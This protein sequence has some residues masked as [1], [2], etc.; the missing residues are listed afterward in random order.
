MHRR[1]EKR[2]SIG[3]TSGGT[4]HGKKGGKSPAFLV[5]PGKKK[6]FPQRHRENRKRGEDTIAC[7]LSYSTSNSQPEGR[8]GRKT[9]FP[10]PT[11]RTKGKKGGKVVRPGALFSYRLGEREGKKRPQGKRRGEKGHCSTHPALAKRK[12]LSYRPIGT[13]LRMRKRGK[14]GER[15]FRCHFLLINSESFQGRG[16]KRGERGYVSPAFF[17][18]VVQP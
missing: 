16:R 3:R 17:K 2:E 9:P 8:K 18:E 15:A 14:R 11:G 7:Q 12:I 4:A 10:T 6:I 13:I 5:S 1:K